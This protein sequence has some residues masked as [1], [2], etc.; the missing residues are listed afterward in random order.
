M[1]SRSQ[2]ATATSNPAGYAISSAINVV[3][4]IAVYL[5]VHLAVGL[6]D[7]VS[8]TAGAA[9]AAAATIFSSISRGRPDGV[10]LLVLT[11]LAVSLVLVLLT[12]NPRVL[13]FKPAILIGV[14]G[15]YLLSTCLRGRA[16]AY[17]TT[18]AALARRD[19][20][21]TAVCEHAWD[22]SPE[23]RS[24]LRVMTGAWGVA[25]LLDGGIRVY[26][27][28]TSPLTKAVVMPPVIDVGLLGIAVV[29][30]IVQFRHIKSIVQGSTAPGKDDQ[31]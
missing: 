14:C 19:P 17:Q 25:F 22:T 8:L 23:F 11:K 10:G 12:R 18:V 5:V 20:R 3:G 30:A 7:V 28:V 1:T 6:S 13:L 26:Y 29:I 16:I 15:L 9:I 4:P 31:S 24:R 2:P 21:M 27:A